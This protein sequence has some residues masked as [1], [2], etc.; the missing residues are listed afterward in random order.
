MPGGPAFHQP[1]HQPAIHP[2]QQPPQLMSSAQA[3]PWTVHPGAAPGV[4]M[5]GQVPAAWHQPAAQ[6][7]QHP[8]APPSIAMPAASQ[9]TPAQQQPQPWPPS[10]P[11]AMDPNTSISVP[12]S[13]LAQPPVPVAYPGPPHPGVA[14]ATIPPHAQGVPSFPQPQWPAQPSYAHGY[15]LQQPHQMQPAPQGNDDIQRPVGG[16]AES[17]QHQVA[18]VTQEGFGAGNAPSTTGLSLSN[19]LATAPAPIMGQLT[20]NDGSE[21]KKA[22]AAEPG[23]A[24]GR[25]IADPG[26]AGHPVQDG[27]GS[28]D[29]DP[30]KTELAG[31]GKAD[32]EAK[33]GDA[34]PEAAGPGGG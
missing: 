1:V 34:Q 23:E 9:F 26:G 22:R 19:E 4:V 5:P 10:M 16:V 2:S 29:A 20:A 8:W 17:S 30:G 14:A 3:G 11:V 6:Q 12:F 28:S 27:A 21:R 15:V 7:Q 25:D 13:R 33:T 18:S 32:G 24:A 31:D